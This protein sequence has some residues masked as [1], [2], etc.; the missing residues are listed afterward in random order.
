METNV[1]YQLRALAGPERLEVLTQR[2]TREVRDLLAPMDGGEV[3]PGVSLFDLGLSSLGEEILRE[4][5]ERAFGCVIDGA[6]MFNHL[7][8]AKLAAYVQHLLFPETRQRL[9]EAGTAQ[10]VSDER[11]LANS[12]I[13]S[14]YQTP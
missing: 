12:L 5:L 11:E 7:T 8:V 6:E 3:P 4:R 1:L 2:V 13:A 9:D 14:L 10:P